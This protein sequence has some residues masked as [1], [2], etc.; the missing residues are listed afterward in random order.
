MRRAIAGLVVVVMIASSA[1]AFAGQK[2]QVLRLINQSDRVTDF[3]LHWMATAL[4]TQLNSDFRLYYHK[5]RAL[6]VVACTPANMES[7]SSRKASGCARGLPIYLRDI[8][9]AA[10]WQGVN[11]PHRSAIVQVQGAWNGDVDFD[12]L[13][14]TTDIADHEIMEMLTG[15]P[16]ADDWENRNYVVC[17]LTMSDFA[18]PH[19][20]NQV[21]ADFCGTVDYCY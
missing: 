15:R 16:V 7:P 14:F 17:G 13:S 10:L 19:S 8:S 11:Q 18:L 2:P 20:R 9:S 4:T 21:P 12:G 1:P 3:D 5:G 6:V